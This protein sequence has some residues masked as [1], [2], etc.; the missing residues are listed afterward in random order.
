MRYISDQPPAAAAGW[1]TVTMFSLAWRSPIEFLQNIPP[2]RN[3]ELRL[4]ATCTGFVAPCCN[5]VPF[6]T[7]IFSSRERVC[8]ACRSAD[9]GTHALILPK[10]I[11]SNATAA[12]QSRVN[13]N[14]GLYR[15]LLPQLLSS[16]LR[17]LMSQA[18]NSRM[19]RIPHLSVSLT[20]CC[21]KS[22]ARWWARC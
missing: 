20:R 22:R 19:K 13:F 16:T 18:L 4:H 3:A 15:V 1:K 14:G 17:R 8:A 9:G 11:L 5:G 2:K 21:Q 6:S 12:E 7:S 10:K